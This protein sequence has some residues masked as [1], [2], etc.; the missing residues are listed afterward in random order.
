M[1]QTKDLTV[2]ALRQAFAI[3]RFYEKAARGGTRYAELVRS[4]FGVV[5]PDARVQRPEYLGGSHVM[6]NVQQVAQTAPGGSDQTSLA[7]LG[8]YSLTSDR[9]GLEA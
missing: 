2:N 4:N 1:T 3:Q 6:L 5:S 9:E 8:A 7:S